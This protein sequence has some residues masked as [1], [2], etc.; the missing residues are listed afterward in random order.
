MNHATEQ[1]S[2]GSVSSAEP[3]DPRVT[4]ALEEYLAALEEG[5]QVDRQEFLA[6]HA[7]IVEPLTK[8]LGGLEFLRSAAQQMHE[9]ASKSTGTTLD[10]L[11][12]GGATTPLGDF[13]I[14]R[15]IG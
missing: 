6:R 14:L 7:E 8:C 13:Q 2:S 10:S 3:N 15:E 5:Q 9:P 12:E 4:G 1:R 11:A